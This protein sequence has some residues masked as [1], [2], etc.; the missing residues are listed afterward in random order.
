MYALMLLWSKFIKD[1]KWENSDDKK[2]FPSLIFTLSKNCA[3]DT[4]IRS[5][6]I[7]ELIPHRE[8]RKKYFDSFTGIKSGPLSF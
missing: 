7:Y 6:Q 5:K 8:D 1:K 2:S 3:L 4:A